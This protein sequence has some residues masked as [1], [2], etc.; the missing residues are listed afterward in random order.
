M[1]VICYFW[2]FQGSFECDKVIGNFLAHNIK[3]VKD[4]V[5]TKKEQPS[6]EIFTIR[7]KNRST[8]KIPDMIRHQVV[9]RLN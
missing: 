2:R 7:E 1:V 5:L 9:G 3:V 4:E 8:G 6:I